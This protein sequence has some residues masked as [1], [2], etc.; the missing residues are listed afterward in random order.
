YHQLHE[1]RS[2]QEIRNLTS[3]A[4]YRRPGVKEK[5]AI[6]NAAAV[7]LHGAKFEL[8]STMIRDRLKRG[9]SIKYLVSPAVERYIR[10]RSLYTRGSRKKKAGT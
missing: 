5:K 4:V 9:E 3:I 6:R 1:W 10:H 7:F 2:P 8:S